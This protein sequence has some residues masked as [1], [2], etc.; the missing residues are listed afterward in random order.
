MSRSPNIPVGNHQVNQDLD[1]L[2][3]WQLSGKI[4]WIT[5]EER[6][7][8]YINWQTSNNDTTFNLN[9]LLGV[10]LARLRTENTVSTLSTDD[11]TFVGD[12]ASLLIFQQTGFR[13]PIEQLKYWVKGQIPDSENYNANIKNEITYRTDGL[14]K[15]LTHNCEYCDV[16]NITYNN[17]TQAEINQT[18][19]VLPSSIELFNPAHQALIKIRIT[20]W[21]G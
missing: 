16:W 13:V 20:G 18:T 17:Y 7:S 8:A 21:S 2:Q 9:N 10:N 4:A 3:S 14:I 15:S 6:K 1:N 12:S 5:P 19:Y 11:K